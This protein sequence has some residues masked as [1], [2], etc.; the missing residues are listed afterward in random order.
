M[1]GGSRVVNVFAIQKMEWWVMEIGLMI[2]F[3]SNIEVIELGYMR[4]RFRADLQFLDELERWKIERM[5][6]PQPLPCTVLYCTVELDRKVLPHFS[7]Y[8]LGFENT[9]PFSKQQT[10]YTHK[11]KTRIYVIIQ[12]YR[13]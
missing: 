6:N 7:C 1:Q 10:R 4:Q 11:L 8:E 3:C 13:R 9:R 2:T 12:T 5:E